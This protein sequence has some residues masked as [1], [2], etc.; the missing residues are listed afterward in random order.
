MCNYFGNPSIWD[1]LGCQ[2]YPIMHLVHTV[3][4]N[5]KTETSKSVNLSYTIFKCSMQVIFLF[6]CSLLICLLLIFF[7]ILLSSI[8]FIYFYSS[9]SVQFILIFVFCYIQFFIF[10]NYSASTQTCFS[11]LLKGDISMLLSSF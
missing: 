4:Q 5:D 9:I 2:L 8:T 11:L 1:N 3:I 10:N 7:E 6:Y